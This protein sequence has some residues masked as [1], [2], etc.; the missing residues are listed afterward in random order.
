MPGHFAR[1]IVK[2]V[3][4]RRL[5]SIV[6]L[7]VLLCANTAVASVCEAYCVVEKNGHHHYQTG[8]TLSSRAH[9]HPPAQ[10]HMAGCAACPNSAGL[11]SPQPQY[12]GN[13]TQALQEPSSTMSSD[14]GVLQLEITRSSI[15]S[16]PAQ[17]ETERFSPFHSPP[18]VSSFDPI[19]VSPRI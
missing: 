13:E 16:L 10:H 15:G 11:A 17:I 3:L 8:T 14:R 7:M 4:H 19:L 2:L 5:V 18:K 12:C 1:S 6:L 9:H